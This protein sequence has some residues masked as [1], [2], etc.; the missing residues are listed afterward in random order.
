[1]AVTTVN[2]TKDRRSIYVQ[3]VP[4]FASFCNPMINR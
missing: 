2:G 4:E 3:V 1:M